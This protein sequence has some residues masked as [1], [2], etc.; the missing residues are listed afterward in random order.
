M[1]EASMEHPEYLV[2]VKRSRRSNIKLLLGVLLGLM[3]FILLGMNAWAEEQDE[4]VGISEVEI[5]SPYEEIDIQSN[6]DELLKIV[7]MECQDE[8]YAGQMAVVETIYNR[9]LHP[10][11]SN[12]IHGVL[13]ERI[14]GHLQFT[15]WKYINHPYNTPNETQENAITEVWLGGSGIQPYL[16]EAQMR[17]EI[18]WSVQ[19]TDYIWFGTRKRGWMHNPIKIG[20]HWF[21]T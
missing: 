21:G 8:P 2:A 6:R 11:F 13:S 15:T 4:S 14:G 12:T 5:V 7:A 19:A 10:E 17:G 18:P 9:V 20:H 1:K 3:V 16:Y